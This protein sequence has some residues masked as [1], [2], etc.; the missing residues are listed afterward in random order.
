ME[1]EHMT[2]R[3]V[4]SFNGASL[5]NSGQLSPLAAELHKSIPS[6]RRNRKS[7]RPIAKPYV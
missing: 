2:D 5:S 7:R 1:E 3:M 6:T 4:V